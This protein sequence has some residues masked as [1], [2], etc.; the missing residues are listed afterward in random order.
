[1]VKSGACISTW[2]RYWRVRVRDSERERE[3][4]GAVVK[5]NGYGICRV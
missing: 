5:T 3:R 1:V 2:S 4:E